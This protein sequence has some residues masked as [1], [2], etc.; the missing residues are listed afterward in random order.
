[1]W[2]SGWDLFLNT[3]THATRD[4][5]KAGHAEHGAAV[6]LSDILVF[7]ATS[8]R[9][10][11]VSVQ[12]RARLAALWHSLLEKIAGGVD[13]FVFEIYG[14][15]SDLHISPRVLRTSANRM[16]GRIDGETAWSVLARS[17]EVFAQTPESVVAIK[18]D[19]KHL[20]GVSN[21]AG[22]RLHI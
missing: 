15:D 22:W 19:E 3:L 13:A 17:R 6:S 5:W 7:C 10:G 2:V 11:R 12:S 4:L 20:S 14:Q 9:H 21:I 1:M 16:R 8:R 18:N